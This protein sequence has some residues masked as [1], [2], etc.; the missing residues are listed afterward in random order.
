MKKKEFKELR[1][2]II[3]EANRISESKGNSYTVGDED[4][5][6]FIKT[7]AENNNTDGYLV[8]SIMLSKQLS[9]IKN[10]IK[11]KGESNESEPLDS[12]I[13]DVINYLMLL[14]ALVE[15]TNEK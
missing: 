5:L 8:L 11:N 13:V 2:R 6:K 4:V 1:Q 3:D 12:R 15:E 10:I 9:A 7:E 14:K